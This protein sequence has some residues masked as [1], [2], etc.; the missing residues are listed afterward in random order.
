MCV[1][2]LCSSIQISLW[3]PSINYYSQRTGVSLLISNQITASIF[4]GDISRRIT[5]IINTNNN[6]LN[7]ILLTIICRLY[8]TTQGRWAIS[9]NHHYFCNW[10]YLLVSEVKVHIENNLDFIPRI[11]PGN[12]Q[13]TWCFLIQRFNK[14]SYLFKKIIFFWK[15]SHFSVQTRH[16]FI[17]SMNI[18][19][20]D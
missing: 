8:Y 17:Y 2:R 15:S 18:Y 12:L 9:L 19:W 13:C 20:G 7:K 11:M 5:K 16:G 1:H 6:G 10:S 14:I 3:F 4:F